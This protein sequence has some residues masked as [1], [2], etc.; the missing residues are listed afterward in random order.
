MSDD[1]DNLSQ[2]Q[3]QLDEIESNNG[4]GSELPSARTTPVKQ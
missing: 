3:S 2:L 1:Y 4:Y